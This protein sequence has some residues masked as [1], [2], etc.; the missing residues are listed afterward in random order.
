MYDEGSLAYTGAGL[1]LFGVHFGLGWL[2]GIG[3]GLIVLGALALR[4]GK[5]WGKRRAPKA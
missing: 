5:K 2:I 4:Y 3:V 1:T